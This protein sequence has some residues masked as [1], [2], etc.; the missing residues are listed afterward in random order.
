MLYSPDEIKEQTRRLWRTCFH[1]TDDFIDIYF[2]EKYSHDTNL[3]IRH[4]GRVVAATQLLPYR[5]TFYGMVTRMGYISGLATLPEYRR[6]GYAANLLH[7]AH[8]RLYRQGAT[9]AMLIPG[10]DDLRHFYEKPQNGAYW[11]SNYRR[12]MPID[13]SEDGPTDKIEVTRPDEWHSSL[14]VFYRQLTRQLPFMVH[15]SEDDFFAALEA[16]D[17]E[18]DNGYTLV[19]RRKGRLVGLCVAVKE[20]DGRVYIRT[21]AI[22][23]ACV[24]AAFVKYLCQ[25]CHTDCV[26]RRYVV[27]GA[28]KDVTPYAMARVI[29]VERFLSLVATPNPD[30][31]L[32]I[33]IDGDMHI[34]EN[35]GYYLVQGGRVQLTDKKPDSIITPGGLAAMFMAAQPMVIDLMLDE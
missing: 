27:P 15:P 25:A 26:Y 22:N 20:A 32:H 12:V 1:D 23:E 13:I 2:N 19:A 3:T 33:G 24:R 35:N 5:L 21:L 8:R 18:G 11:T 14:Y 4:E 9:L 30:F 31:Q 17:L 28:T 7:E 16:V 10:D 6:K 29:N 34:P